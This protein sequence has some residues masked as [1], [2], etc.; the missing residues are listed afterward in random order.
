MLGVGANRPTGDEIMLIVTVEGLW[1]RSFSKSA[2]LAICDFIRILDLPSAVF[3]LFLSFG[4]SIS[5]S[6]TS[7]GTSAN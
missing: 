7:K 1:S 6:A 3:G 2:S 5:Y 4:L